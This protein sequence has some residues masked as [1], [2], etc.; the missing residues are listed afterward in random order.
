MCIL[1]EVFQTSAHKTIAYEAEVQ[2]ESPAAL[3]LY[4][5]FFAPFYSLLLFPL[6]MALD[7]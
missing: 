6:V 3:L 2:T 7:Q 1:T 5:S 4:L